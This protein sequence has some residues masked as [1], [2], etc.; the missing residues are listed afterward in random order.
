MDKEL[1][2]KCWGWE[3]RLLQGKLLGFLLVN[4]LLFLAFVLLR[5]AYVQ[6]QR[7]PI[8]TLVMGLG[9]NLIWLY[10]GV[11]G[12][13]NWR[14]FWGEIRDEPPFVRAP[15]LISTPVV[16][17]WVVPIIAVVLWLVA[18]ILVSLM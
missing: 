11:S 15:V 12:Q 17:G 16:L 5:T 7:L 13:R 4:G 14:F 18:L 1:L 3:N 6:A 9:V 8:A 2:T 10:L